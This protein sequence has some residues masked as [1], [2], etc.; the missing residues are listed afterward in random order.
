MMQ[1]V[2]AK[3]MPVVAYNI[4]EDEKGREPAANKHQLR[5]ILHITL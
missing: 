5:V 1:R 3:K 2:E 4:P